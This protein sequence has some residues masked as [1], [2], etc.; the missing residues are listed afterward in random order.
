MRIVNFSVKDDEVEYFK[1]Y[2]A[3]FDLECVIV[4]A[5]L[6]PKTAYLLEGADA[7]TDSMSHCYDEQIYQLMQQQG[8]KY[9]SLRSAGF[10]N[11]NCNIGSQYGIRFA[12]VA[13]YSPNAIA[14]H[15][16]ALALTLLRNLHVGYM[17]FH[18]QDYRINGLIG[19]EVRDFTVGVL[20]TGH[21]GQ[22]AAKI[23]QGFGGKV[24]AY[25]V[26][27]NPEVAK[28]LDYVDDFDQFLRQVDLLAIYLPLNSSTEH[29]INKQAISKMPQGS[30][31]I[32]VARG[33]H[34]DTEAL[35]QGLKSGHLGGAALDVYENEG[36]I[37]HKDLS[38]QYIDDEIF[39]KLESMPNTFITPH[40]AYNTHRAVENMVKV[41]LEN[42]IE[43][44]EQDQI[45]NEIM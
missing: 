36:M 32:N 18:N 5:G 31:I 42:V 20:G 3:Q 8:I 43:M 28:W 23:W 21:I 13:S 16:V 33:G 29:I 24:L 2:S 39:R 38:C 15:S 7:V 19:R 9:F 4:K 37:Y 6:S 40:I 27:P 25:D 26:N 12:R 14:E 45:D 22:V 35:Y 44:S 34:I 41:A 1:K 11:L 10:D 17:R 30:I